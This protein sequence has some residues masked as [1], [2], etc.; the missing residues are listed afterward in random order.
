MSLKQLKSVKLI[1]KHSN[2]PFPFFHILPLAGFE[3]VQ[4]L[5][6]VLQDENSTTEPW[7]PV[8]KDDTTD[9]R[10]NIFMNPTN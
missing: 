2:F 10:E 1:Q 4:V 7:S 3:P 5:H 9:D 8:V 6:Q